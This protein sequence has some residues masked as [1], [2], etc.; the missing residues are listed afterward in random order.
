VS[1]VVNN[2]KP[3][4]SVL[5]GGGASLLVFLAGCA[6]VGAGVA[7]PPISILGI[8]LIAAS[9]PITMTMV[10]AA[11]PAIGHLVSSFVPATYN[12]QLNQ[13]ATKIGTDV[14]NLKAWVPQ[15]QK[16]YP[17]DPKSPPSVTNINQSGS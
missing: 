13:F 9:T 17:G 5:A 4:A 1:S 16:S 14:D 11:A 2:Y 8:H 3:D 12:Q 6:L 15:I 7:I 10:A